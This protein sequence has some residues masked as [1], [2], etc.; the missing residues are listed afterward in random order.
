MPKINNLQGK[1]FGR[2]TV[3]EKSYEKKRTSWLCKCICGNEIT[4]ATDKLNSQ[5]TRSCGCLRLEKSKERIDALNSIQK[6]EKHP[7]WCGDLRSE[8]K[9]ERFT[10]D[11]KQWKKKALLKANFTCNK[12]GNIGGKLHVH[13][14]FSFSKHPELRTE[15]TNSAVLCK[16]CHRKFHL[17]NGYI[18]GAWQYLNY[19]Y[20]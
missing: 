10:E 12:C 18:T 13:H 4:V 14:I 15:E 7:R 19:I 5:W 6:K 20:A 9:R 3:I 16:N 2:L 8:N 1:V 17:E 11:I